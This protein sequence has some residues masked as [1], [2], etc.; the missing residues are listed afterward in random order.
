MVGFL[1]VDVPRQRAGS[2]D[3]AGVSTAAARTGGRGRGGRFAGDLVVVHGRVVDE[4]GPQPYHHPPPNPRYSRLKRHPSSRRRSRAVGQ[5]GRASTLPRGRASWLW[6]RR[7]SSRW[8]HP[9]ENLARFDARPDAT[10]LLMYVTRHDGVDHPR[11]RLGFDPSGPQIDASR[12]G[13]LCGHPL[14]TGLPGLEASQGA[15]GRQGHGPEVDGL[16]SV[17]R[18]AAETRAVGWGSRS[19]LS[20]VGSPVPWL[21]IRPQP[22]VQHRRD[23]GRSS[24]LTTGPA[25][26]ASTRRAAS[27]CVRARRR[28]RSA[29]WVVLLRWTSKFPGR[30][31]PATTSARTA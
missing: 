23:R 18:V 27:S 4:R 7:R 28:R 10:R 25:R 15:G 6:R 20:G 22:R 21:G 3:R 16:L 1:R 31:R 13:R 12:C 30:G 14:N 2:A 9:R 19:K 29:S 8:L 5:V 17:F 26:S 24:L 11:S